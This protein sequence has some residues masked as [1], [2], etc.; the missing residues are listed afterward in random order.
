MP[1]CTYSRQ[2]SDF[3][4]RIGIVI[5]WLVVYPGEDAEEAEEAEEADS[6]EEATK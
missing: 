6:E 1:C 2:S 3:S 4:L 5:S